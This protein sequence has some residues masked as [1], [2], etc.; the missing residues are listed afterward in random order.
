MKSRYLS[1]SFFCLFILLSFFAFSAHA[2]PRIDATTRI[3]MYDQYRGATYNKKNESGIGWF[4]KGYWD[5]QLKEKYNLEIAKGDWQF[6]SNRGCGLLACANAL[7]WLTGEKASDSRQIEILAELLS[8]YKDPPSTLD[9]YVNYIISHYKEHGIKKL[10]MG[11]SWTQMSNALDNGGV[12]I[13]TST[14]HYAIIVGYTEQ[15]I[16]GKNIRW[17]HVIDSSTSS[18]LQ[19]LPPVNDKNKYTAYDYSFSNIIENRWAKSG[20][21][22]QYWI[23]ISEFIDTDAFKIRAVLTSETAKTLADSIEN[24]SGISNTPSITLK[25]GST[26]PGNKDSS[27]S[28]PTG[29]PRGELTLGKQFGLRGIIESNETISTVTA[30]IININT[31]ENISSVGSPQT[32]NPNTKSFNIKDSNINNNL[33][34]NNLD[35]GAY[36]FSVVATTISGYT[37]TIIDEIFTIGNIEKNVTSIEILN[38]EGFS[39][40]DDEID[41]YDYLGISSDTFFIQAC[42]EPY[43]A[44]NTNIIWTSSNPTVLSLIESEN[45]GDGYTNGYFRINGSGTTIIRASSQEN[46]AIYAQYTLNII[47]K[48]S[49]FFLSSSTSQI[50]PGQSININ[51]TFTPS[52]TSNQSLLWNNDN[53]S[54]IDLDLSG[55][56]VGLSPGIA[57]ITAT[58]VDGSNISKSIRITVLSNYS[59]ITQNSHAI[60]TG[61]NGSGGNI[62]IPGT[63]DGYPVKAIGSTAFME[64]KDITGVALSEGIEEIGLGAFAGC[65]N[66]TSLSLPE[67][68]RIIG[69]SA[70]MNCNIL[71]LSIPKNVYSIEGNPFCCNSNLETITVESGSPYFA[72]RYNALYTADLTKIICTAYGYRIG[73]YDVR[74]GTIFIGREC[75][76]GDRA[77][78]YYTIA[79]GVTT[80]EAYAFYNCSELKEIQ[81]P[82]SV[83]TIAATAFQNCNQ[84]T[85]NT[86]QGSY[87]D[88]YAQE[89]N[90]PVKYYGGSCGEDLTWKLEDNMLTISGNGDMYI[91]AYTNNQPPWYA[92][93]NKITSLVINNGVTQIGS[94]AFYNCYNLV[95]ISLPN[96]LLTIMDD[97]FAQCTSLVDISLPNSITRID[98]G[99]FADCT[100]LANINIPD[101]VVTLNGGTFKNCNLQYVYIPRNVATIH[102]GTFTVSKLN[103]LYVY[104]NTVGAAF[105]QAYN[106]AYEYLDSVM[107]NPDLTLPSALIIIEE[108]AFAGNP[109][110]WIKLSAKVTTIGPRAFADCMNL[111]EIYIPETATSISATAFEGVPAGL[112]IYTESGSYAAFYAT[113]NGYDVHILP[114]KTAAQ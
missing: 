70:F 61:F 38:S 45:L 62:T 89:N 105:A 63:V 39:L 84:V 31:N 46:D 51:A 60:I 110:E 5:T 71:H 104:K 10:S 18:T 44:Y 111:T 13:F 25:A 64:R 76:Y 79:D 113:N 22:G 55:R 17:L 59:Y 49:D 6:I 98:S 92:M 74:E 103:T 83:T 9:P 8:Q 85:I 32:S 68:L 15:Y 107:D 7:Q 43:D 112:T 109:A 94:D 30:K 35:Y 77:S 21:Y 34:F 95:N 69:E 3:S 19:K 102:A 58:T 88:S 33:L 81:I 27:E 73:Y 99:A 106:I 16:N 65:S 36:R 75:F 41:I 12:I 100:S 91:Y 86:I 56:V 14:G 54:V 82:E 57:T 4:T 72:S 47:R 90:I 2:S 96:S 29:F 87:A 53:P 20:N 40:N 80:I 26:W 28:I 50:Y 97:A 24:N 42:V 66:L 93:R 37:Q 23:N 108:E 101:G 78:E 67:S 1:I 48:A 11:K 52:D 114:S